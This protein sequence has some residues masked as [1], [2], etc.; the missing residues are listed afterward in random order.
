[1]VCNY[2]KI[3]HTLYIIRIFKNNCNTLSPQESFSYITPNKFPKSVTATLISKRNCAKLISEMD[4][5]RNSVSK[6]THLTNPSSTNPPEF[7]R[8]VP[9]SHN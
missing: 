3:K 5:A 6:Q 2:G 4:I 7:G 1:M 9:D 8:P